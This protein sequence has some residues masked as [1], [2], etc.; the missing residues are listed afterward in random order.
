MSDEEFLLTTAN[1]RDHL[2]GASGARREPPSTPWAAVYRSAYCW[3][4]GR[5]ARRGWQNNRLP[6]IEEQLG[7]RS[8][9]GCGA[10]PGLCALV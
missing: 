6:R 5:P 7:G 2:A 1:L 3:W 8:A 4:D 10:P 9:S